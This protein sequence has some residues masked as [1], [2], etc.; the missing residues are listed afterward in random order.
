MIPSLRNDLSFEVASVF[1]SS[2]LSISF[3]LTCPKLF[4]CPSHVTVKDISDV[5]E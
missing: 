3:L 5:S 4:V 2:S 1:N